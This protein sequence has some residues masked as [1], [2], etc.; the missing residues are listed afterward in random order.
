MERILC[1]AIKRI[2]PREKCN[3]HQNDI[4]LIE[5]G[6]RHH[7]ILIRFKG[8]VSRKPEDQGFYTSKGRFV[9]RREA[10]KIAKESGQIEIDNEKT[11]L[12]SED[13]Y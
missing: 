9:D 3:Y 4:H 13:L 10:C 2:K 12:Y 8:E 6:Y 7:D 11:V 5:I 1:S